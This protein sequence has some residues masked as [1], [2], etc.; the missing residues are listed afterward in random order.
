MKPMTMEQMFAVADTIRIAWEAAATQHPAIS[1]LFEDD[2]PYLTIW[3]GNRCKCKHGRILENVYD[4]PG[5]RRKAQA[6]LC[7]MP[8]ENDEEGIDVVNVH[9]PSGKVR[10][11]DS[12]RYHLI[13][14]LLQSSSMARANK[15]IG[16]GRF[17]LGGDMNTDEVC[18]SQIL[19]K[20]RSLGI[21]QTSNEVLS[22]TWGK[23]GDTCVVGGFTTT[24]V[25]GRARNH[26]PQH[27]PYGI[28]WRRQPQ[29]ATEQL[30]T[31]P[32]TQIPT[33]P[34]TKKES[35][36]TGSI[37]AAVATRRIP[38]QQP[39]R[40]TAT[41][42]TTTE[43]PQPDPQEVAVRPERHLSQ[44]PL[45]KAS[46]S[47]WPATEQPDGPGEIVTIRPDRR[48]SQLPLEKVY[49]TAWPAT[50][51]PD[52]PVETGT[53]QHRTDAG[54]VRTQA[55]AEITRP[56]TE[57]SQSDTEEPPTQKGPEQMGAAKPKTKVSLDADTETTRHATEQPRPD[58]NEPPA[59]NG[60]EQEIA[61]VIV[62]A[63]L[64]NVTFESAEAEGL[65]R[66]IILTTDKWPPDMLHNIDEVFRP[67][68]FNYPNGLSDRTRAE[69][70]DASQ[71]IRQWREIAE[72]R[73]CVHECVPRGSQLAASQVQ[74]ILH[75]YID[76]FIHN[77]ADDT[78]RA[79]SWNKNKSRAEARLRRLCG[80]VLMA[81]A[82][83][84]VGLPNVPEAMFATERAL[85]ML[86]PATEQQRRLGRDLLDSIAAATEWILTWLNML[87]KSIQSHKATPVYQEHARKSGTQK[88]QSGLTATELRVKEEKKR[89]AHQKYG[90]R[91]S[92]A[93]ESQWQWR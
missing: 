49:Q 5:H 85:A 41:T 55:D 24:L 18:L 58:E 22:P 36:A 38:K 32:Q 13:R 40:D 86:V 78:Q 4:V 25:R 79:E 53:V 70:R 43:Q 69:P 26:D 8:G 20:L 56:T 77:E 81:K 84:Q 23:H 64:D 1:F 21:L 14:N 31:T 74:S 51:Q 52:E 93:P 19:N 66:R 37:A 90:R 17:L 46:A 29:H 57:Q 44:L 65:I 61:Y 63:F 75:Q 91:P 9:V 47:A 33:A 7:I 34:D 72:W 45:E 15:Q 89:E 80:S 62:N 28:A 27:E 60:P 68:F 82:I 71:Y 10:L 59:L 39:H 83:W 67:I 54:V 92:A 88:N 12:Q 16:E 50:E 87:A 35:G 30:T 73:E 42:W 3:D 76:N 6:F 2:A 11:T 48:L